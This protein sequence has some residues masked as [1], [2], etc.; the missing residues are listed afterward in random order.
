MDN[1]FLSSFL[2]PMMSMLAEACHFSNCGI[3]LVD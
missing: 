2:K 1:F 3:F